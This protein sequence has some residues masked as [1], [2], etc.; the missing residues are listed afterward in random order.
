MGRVSRYWARRV[1]RGICGQTG[2][3]V[4]HRGEGAVTVESSMVIPQT[5]NKITV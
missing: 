5:I 3:L 2:A 1:G 4:H